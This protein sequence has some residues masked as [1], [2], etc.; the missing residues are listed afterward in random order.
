M[1]RILIL[2]VL[3]KSQIAFTQDRPIDVQHYRFEISLSDSTN[4]I[5]GRA[6]ITAR[7]LGPASEVTFDLI[8]PKNDTGMLAYRAFEGRRRLGSVQRDNKITLTL[9]KKAKPGDVRTFEIQYSGI[10]R[11]GLI[12]SKNKYGDRT[13]FADNWPD[14]ARNW[15]PCVD[16][17]ADKASVEFKVTAPS[18]YGVVS[19]GVL[20]YQKNHEDGNMSTE[21]KETALLP[22]KVMVIGV[23][24]FAVQQLGDTLGVA[25]SSWVYPK[26]KEKLFYD[27][28]LA[29]DMLP[30][31]IKNI[32]PFPYRKLA[33]VQSKTIFGGMENAGC[34]FYSEAVV[35]G[36]R[37]SEDLLAHEIA[38]QWFGN[39]ATE[40]SFAHLWLSEGFAT[41]FTDLYF[42][43]KYG[44]DA[45]NT[46]LKE[47]RD[48]VIKFSKRSKLPVVDSL[49]KN[50][51]QLLNA[52]SYQKG[53]WSLHMLRGLLGHATFMNGVRA[54]FKQYGGGNASTDDFRKVME[55]AS[56]K[57]L[58]GFF[59]QWL[60]TAGHPVLQV[61]QD[62][63]ATA[64]R[65]TL[66]VTQQQPTAF[67]FPLEVQVQTAAGAVVKTF[68]VSQ[69]QQVFTVDGVTGSEIVLD[70]GTRLLFEVAM[71]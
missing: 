17:P 41:Y 32:A 30:Y 12:I 48:Q 18:K 50:F 62:L 51:M 46:R 68:Q 60:Y 2:L 57:D 6:Y 9:D 63:D 53:A 64:G 43:D 27:Y 13:F 54:Y 44:Q 20:V 38:H 15:I 31:F 1:K 49:T 24:D 59:R 19:N 26:D 23:A 71:K 42:L 70:P 29:K 11:D 45:M 65:L 16:D 3:I 40:K 8:N 28:A 37:E 7:F 58:S 21:W 22:T 14:R 4:R 10:P 5:E 61:K 55:Q 56:G 35:S 66:T 69:Q 52:N 34:I 36:K 47:E 67:S 39:T 33:N 25:V